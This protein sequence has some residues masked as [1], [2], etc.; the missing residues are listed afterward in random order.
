MHTPNH[1]QANQ[2]DRNQSYCRSSPQALWPQACRDIRLVSLHL[3]RT[4]RTQSSVRA[5]RGVVNRVCRDMRCARKAGARQP[6]YADNAACVCPGIHKPADAKR[7]Y[8][9][10]APSIW[11]RMAPHTQPDGT[12]KAIPLVPI[13]S[14]LNNA[15]RGAP[16]GT[17]LYSAARSKRAESLM[18]DGDGEVG[19]V[20][21]PKYRRRR[22][23][24][25]DAPNEWAAADQA[26]SG[27]AASSA[28]PS[29]SSSSLFRPKSTGE[30]LFSHG[31]SHGS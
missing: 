21:P 15:N 31:S 12:S 9:S 3:F 22:M 29:A 16:N 6:R 13:C 11:L 30:E 10:S 19:Y 8:R 18:D 1:K 17:S 27:S 4:Q 7:L 23:C 20:N 28:S 24:Q 14:V 25:T 26:C 5:A 2:V